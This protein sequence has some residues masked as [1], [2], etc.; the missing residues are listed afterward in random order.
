[1][2]LSPAGKRLSKAF[3]EAGLSTSPIKIRFTKKDRKR[4]KE[5]MK[6]LKAINDASEAAGKS[7]LRFGN[8]Q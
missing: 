5:L 4:N 6:F 7:N 1:M 3:K 2:K 8:V